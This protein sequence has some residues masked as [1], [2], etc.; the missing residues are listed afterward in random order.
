MYTKIE[1][2]ICKFNPAGPGGE[3][4]DCG[5]SKEHCVCGLN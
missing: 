1:T 4:M 3:C 5:A 2:E